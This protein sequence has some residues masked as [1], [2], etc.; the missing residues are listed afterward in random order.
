[1]ATIEG[2]C[3][4]MSSTPPKD[5]DHW[6]KK[7][8]E[9]AK[10]DKDSAVWDASF[11]YV[12]DACAQLGPT[13]MVKCTHST[14][15]ASRLKSKRKLDE[16]NKGVSMDAQ[17][18]ARENLGLLTESNNKAFKSAHV[19]RLFAKENHYSPIDVKNGK[20]K[21]VNTEFLNSVCEF[22][23]KKIPFIMC[24]IDPNAAGAN[25]TAIVFITYYEMR[26]IYLWIDRRNT[27]EFGQFNDF[28]IETLIQ[29]HLDIRRNPN[30]KI[31]LA[32]ESQSRWDGSWVKYFVNENKLKYKEL[33]NIVFVSDVGFKHPHEG[34]LIYESRY[35]DAIKK[36]SIA[37]S[38]AGGICIYEKFG[39]LNQDGPEEMLNE[40]MRQL[41]R[42]IHFE[43]DFCSKYDKSGR[44]RKKNNTGKISGY[45]DDVAVAMILSY[46]WLIIFGDDE[47]YKLQRDEFSVPELYSLI[48]K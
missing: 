42:Y 40:A 21:Q 38:T 48:D 4:I 6:I 45:N 18:A 16:M 19:K 10:E 36:L 20:Y 32:V 34:V 24:Y 11:S 25:D 15:K 35:R 5:D 26:Y 23:D 39:T 28:I 31:V 29:F 43:D 17:K 1:M 27:S 37:L 2:S 47:K 41:L 3:M 13:E 14:M 44:K 12:C 7:I 8:I 22:D 30:I 46:L 33:R 9:G